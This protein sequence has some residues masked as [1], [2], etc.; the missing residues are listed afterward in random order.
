MRHYIVRAARPAA[1]TPAAPTHIYNTNTS[2]EKSQSRVHSSRPHA[3]RRT[4]SNFDKYSPY[5]RI[6][7]SSGGKKEPLERTAWTRRLSEYAALFPSGSRIKLSVPGSRPGYRGSPRT[8]EH[9]NR[10]YWISASGGC[11]CTW[12]YE[13]GGRGYAAAAT[14]RETSIL[15]RESSYLITAPRARPARRGCGRH[16]SSNFGLLERID[17]TTS[18]RAPHAPAAL[19]STLSARRFPREKCRRRFSRP[20]LNSDGNNPPGGAAL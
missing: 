8:A 10:K 7:R 17:M 1:L 15:E 13:G 19:D 16:L 2:V 14:R 18:H 12:H 4:T 11:A 9:L 3:R 20:V 5:R 6:Y